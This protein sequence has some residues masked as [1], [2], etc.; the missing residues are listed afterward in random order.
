MKIACINTY[1]DR[2]STQY[3]TIDDADLPLETLHGGDPEAA[4]E[5][6]W[7]YLWTFTGD[8]TGENEHAWYE[9]IIL[10]AADPA[11]VGLSNEWDG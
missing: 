11:L 10:D 1:S 9:V 2:T 8:G 3:H 7:D 4:L 6:L 5:A